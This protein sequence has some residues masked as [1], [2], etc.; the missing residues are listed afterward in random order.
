MYVF[1]ESCSQKVSK[2]ELKANF[3]GILNV[4]KILLKGVPENYGNDGKII[5]IW[6]N[7]GFLM[8]LWEITSDF[9]YLSYF[10]NNG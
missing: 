8:V 6:G 1:E 9:F 10:G 7:L 5:L 3:G 2:V 4:F